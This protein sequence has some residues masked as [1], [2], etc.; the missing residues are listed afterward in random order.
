[1]KVTSLETFYITF[2]KHIALTAAY[3]ED[4][5]ISFVIKSCRLKPTQIIFGDYSE[6]IV[7]FRDWFDEHGNTLKITDKKKISIQLNDLAIPKDKIIG[8]DL[9]ENLPID[10]VVK[11]SK[12]MFVMVGK[13]EDLFKDHAII[14]LLGI[15]GFLRSYC[16]LYGEWSKIPS[17]HLGFNAL[18]EIERNADIKFFTELKV[19]NIPYP[20][21]NSKALLTCLPAN[22]AFFSTLKNWNEPVFHKI[23]RSDT[24]I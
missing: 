23:Y 7:L 2:D 22:E 8:S 9:Y 15:D 16:Y 17:L 20:C 1:M 18:R 4:T 6:K 10:K 11:I 19:K 14:S 3:L 24:Y 12:L 5:T 21:I 13:D